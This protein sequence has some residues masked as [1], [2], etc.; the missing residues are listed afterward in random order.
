M[1]GFEKRDDIFF[2]DNSLGRGIE[3]IIIIIGGGGGR[4]YYRQGGIGRDNLCL[5]EQEVELD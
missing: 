5:E 4:E 3:E 1:D 2:K